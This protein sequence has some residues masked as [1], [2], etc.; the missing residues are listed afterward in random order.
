MTG[1]TDLA[2]LLAPLPVDSF[3]AEVWGRRH[4]HGR[5]PAPDRFAALL[6]D[7][8][9]EEVLAALRPQP[10]ML[11]LVSQ[12][13]TLPFDQLVLPDGAVDLVQVRNRYAEGHSIVLNGV[14]RFAPELRLLTNAIAADTDFETQINVYATPPRAQG[15]APH[16]DDHDVLVLQVRG[17]KIWHVHLS[18]PIVPPERFRQRERAVD[19]ATLG[20]PTRIV[21]A[22]GD[23]LYLPRGLVHAAETDAGASVHLTIGFHPPNLLAVLSAALEARSLS[24]G[25]LLERAPPRYLGDRAARARLAA[26]VRDL[27]AALDDGDVDRGLAAL[28]DR[29]IRSARCGVTGDFIGAGETAIGRDTRLRRSTPLPARL[30]DLGESVGLQFAQ[31]L[32]VADREHRPAFEYLLAQSGPFAVAD[33]P[34]LPPEAQAALAEKLIQDG[35]LTQA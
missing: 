18:S 26:A 34:G 9:L 19:P 29:L 15:F 3:F 2:A 27:A 21:L 25:T 7:R 8:R 14:E 20:E 6:P 28:E 13:Q 10:D 24:G 11:R 32:V 5:A 30:V 4:H 23:V 1:P 31:A 17:S 22:P 16:F 12:G 35:F 33:L